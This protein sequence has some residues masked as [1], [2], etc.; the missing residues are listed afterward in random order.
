MKSAIQLA[1]EV[2]ILLLLA[3]LTVIKNNEKI[4][5]KLYTSL[6]VK[7][8]NLKVNSKTGGTWHWVGQ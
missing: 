4:K 1:V 8:Q 7:I 3:I 5:K 6:G 2:L